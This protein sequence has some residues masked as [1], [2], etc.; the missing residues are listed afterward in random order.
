M[1]DYLKQ[2]PS[3]SPAVVDIRGAGS[4]PDVLYA[5]NPTEQT[6]QDTIAVILLVFKIM[7]LYFTPTQQ[8]IDSGLFG[9]LT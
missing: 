9:E 6:I 2:V 7:F 4:Y 3:V 5:R 8:A 1:T